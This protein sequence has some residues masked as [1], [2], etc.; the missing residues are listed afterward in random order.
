MLQ[1]RQT[2][3]DLLLPYYDNSECRYYLGRFII[4]RG[5]L[6]GIRLNSAKNIH[7]N[8]WTP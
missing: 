7:F 4:F 1:F 8:S 2:I 6:L 5:Q 3:I